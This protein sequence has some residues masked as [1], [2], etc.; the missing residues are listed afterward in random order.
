MEYQFNIKNRK[1]IK[2][3]TNSKRFVKYPDM[4]L[5]K[6]C[7]VRV[8]GDEFLNSDEFVICSKNKVLPRKICVFGKKNTGYKR[9]ENDIYLNYWLNIFLK[10]VEEG[11]LCK[12]DFTKVQS[13]L[14]LSIGLP[15]EYRRTAFKYK[16]WSR[17]NI[18]EFLSCLF[19]IEIE[20]ESYEQQDLL[21]NLLVA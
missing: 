2:K 5:S 17:D 19:D 10:T 8:N 14:E 21:E 12:Y 1:D 11:N 20:E 18:I 16:N 13:K 4:F 3:L 6:T 9:N 7:S 15:L